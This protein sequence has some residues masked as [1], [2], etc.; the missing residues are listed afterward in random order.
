ML[1]SAYVRERTAQFS[2]HNSLSGAT[3]RCA[4]FCHQGG[5]IK[6]INFLEWESNPQR[7]VYSYA[8]KA[9]QN[10]KQIPP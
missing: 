8:T 3:Q 6:I 7:R 9:S 1:Y 10:A 5:E 4:L 2:R